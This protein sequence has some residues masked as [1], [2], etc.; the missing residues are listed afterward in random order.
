MI[1]RFRFPLFLAAILFIG[2]TLEPSVASFQDTKDKK[3]KSE[4]AKDAKAKDEKAKEAPAKSDL[5]GTWEVTK[6]DE[7]NESQGGM[8]KAKFT[9]AGDKLTVQIEKETIPF[10]FK[11]DAAK[12]PK[13]IDFQESLVKDS[14][15]SQGIYE[16]TGDVLKICVA[17]PDLKER[18][19]EFKSTKR[20]VTY[21]ELKKDKS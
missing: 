13:T 10:T 14:T 9:F 4:P 8:V 19:T 21:L 1:V 7:N 11:T 16:I 17:E 2:V 15:S 12:T 5:E 20:K 6:A 18:P 3:D